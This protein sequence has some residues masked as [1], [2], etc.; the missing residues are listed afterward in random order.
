MSNFPSLTPKELI[1]VL[2]QNGFVLKHI[3]GSHHFF[4]NPDNGKIAVV[5]VHAKDLPKGTLHSILKQAGIGKEDI[6]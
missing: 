4:I 1:K 5:P 6:K 3:R 2:E